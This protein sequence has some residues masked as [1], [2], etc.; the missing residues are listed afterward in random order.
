M[1]TL[2]GNVEDFSYYQNLEFEIVQ[3]FCNGQKWLRSK[4]SIYGRHMISLGGFLGQKKWKS[5]KSLKTCFFC[6]LNDSETKK[7]FFS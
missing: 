4:I 2:S 5:Q 7:K 1:L 3:Q 6:E